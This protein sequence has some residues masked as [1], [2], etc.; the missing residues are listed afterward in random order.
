MARLCAIKH[1]CGDWFSIEHI[2]PSTLLEQDSY[3]ELL[4]M[5]G[6]YMFTFD[7]CEYGEEYR[8]RQCLITNQ[9]WLAELSRDCQRD[10]AHKL[11]TQHAKGQKAGVDY[12][13]A[14][15]V[16]PF[17]ERLCTKWAELY[18]RGIEGPSAQC[19]PF[20]ADE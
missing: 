7:N 1:M 6:V 16:S 9:P 17:S 8:H 15:A 10:H 12:V 13:P 18:Q 5:P 14:H 11:V 20:C 2:Y 4:A 19:C 3:K